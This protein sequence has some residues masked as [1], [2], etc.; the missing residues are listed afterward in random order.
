MTTPFQK[1]ARVLALEDTPEALLRRCLWLPPAAPVTP[2]RVEDFER[3]VLAASATLRALPERAAPERTEDPERAALRAPPERAGDFERAARRALE[4]LAELPAAA[5]DPARR[6]LQAAALAGRVAP[7]ADPREPRRVRHA[8]A[9]LVV[10]AVYA[11]EVLANPRLR[12]SLL[13]REFLATR[14]RLKRLRRCRCHVFDLDRDPLPGT[15]LHAHLV[16]FEIAAEAPED[17][18]RWICTHPR[19]PGFPA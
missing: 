14:D 9:G 5:L 19:A 2:A 7:E 4:A 17:I 10:R 6:A 12:Q 11:E 8:P 1:A 3:A 18:E 16:R 13:P 15:A